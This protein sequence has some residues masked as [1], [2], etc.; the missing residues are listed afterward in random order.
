MLC[1][2]SKSSL[3]DLAKMMACDP[4][5][6]YHDNRVVLPLRVAEVVGLPQSTP[7]PSL[8]PVVKL[9]YGFETYATPIGVSE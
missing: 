2:F 9:L 3:S 6:G 1:G 5:K 7:K 4:I 8:I